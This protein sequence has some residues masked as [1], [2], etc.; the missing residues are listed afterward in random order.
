MSSIPKR[1]LK[2]IQQVEW[3]GTHVAPFAFCEQHELPQGLKLKKC[4]A[5]DGLMPSV[6]ASYYASRQNHD[7]NISVGHTALC[8]L[9]WVRTQ[10]R[11]KGGS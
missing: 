2:L 3:A 5:C 8:D 6:L 1:V 10:Y 4:P 9:Q 11:I 7:S